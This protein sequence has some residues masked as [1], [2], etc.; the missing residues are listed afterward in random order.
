[1][2]EATILFRNFVDRSAAA[3]ASLLRAYEQCRDQLG[4]P[5]EPVLDQLMAAGSDLHAVEAAMRRRNP[6]NGLTKRALVMLSLAESHPEFQE[7][8]VLA[9]PRRV[10]AWLQLLSAPLAGAWALCKGT[11]LLRWYGSRV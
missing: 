1:M 2:E 7:L 4:L 9:R 3:P 10:G 5:Q 11:L 8:F 6:E